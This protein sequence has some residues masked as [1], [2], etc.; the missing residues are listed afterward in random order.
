[1]SIL[2]YRTECTIMSLAAAIQVMWVLWISTCKSCNQIAQPKRR[3]VPRVVKLKTPS[4]SVLLLCACGGT[5]ATWLSSV[6]NPCCTTEYRLSKA[7][8]WIQNPSETFDVVTLRERILVHCTAETW[9]FLSWCF[10]HFLKSL[11]QL[12]EGSRLNR[13]PVWLLLFGQT[14]GNASLEGRWSKVLK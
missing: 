2:F 14:V 11:E 6:E 10:Y 3:L 9:P 8:V 7:L 4:E 5:N 1:M 13:L 12:W